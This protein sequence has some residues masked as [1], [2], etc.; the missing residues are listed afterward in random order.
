MATALETAV[1]ITCNDGDPEV[2]FGPI[3][4]LVIG[5]LYAW[6]AKAL[7]IC[8]R[9]LIQKRCLAEALRYPVSEQHGVVGGMT[10]SQRRALMLAGRQ[11]SGLAA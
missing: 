1:R 10:A 5:K 7:A 3:D 4:S 6:E 2:F 8:A 9:C 11:K